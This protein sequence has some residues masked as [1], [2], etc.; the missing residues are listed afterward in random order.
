MRIYKRSKLF[1]GIGLSVWVPTEYVVTA[2]GIV[3]AASVA[4]RLAT[5]ALS[6]CPDELRLQCD[7]G[8]PILV[9]RSAKGQR[10]NCPSCHQQ[11]KVPNFLA[12]KN[13]IVV[14]GF[15]L[16]IGLFLL[17]AAMSNQ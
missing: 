6:Y 4:E 5:N 2:L 9:N 14:V 3:A 15:I 10:F 8:Q 17:F 7:C 1:G 12:I 13:F 16:A 11:L